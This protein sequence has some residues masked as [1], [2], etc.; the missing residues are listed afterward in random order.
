MNIAQILIDISEFLA[1]L[2]DFLM[3]L[4]FAPVT[5]GGVETNFLNVVFAVGIPLIIFVLIVKALLK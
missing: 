4:I 2:F 3:Q 5:V 1:N